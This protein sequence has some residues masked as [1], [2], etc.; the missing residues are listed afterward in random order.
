MTTKARKD[1]DHKTLRFGSGDYYVLC[2]DCPAYW[3]MSYP[4]KDEAWAAGAN[5]GVANSSLNGHIRSAND[6]GDEHG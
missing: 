2:V 3:V 4:G 6:G 5:T 1:C